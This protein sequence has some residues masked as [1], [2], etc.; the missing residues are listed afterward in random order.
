VTLKH[1]SF[2]EGKTAKNRVH[3]DIRCSAGPDDPEAEQKIEAHANKLAEA[4]GSVIGRHR[5]PSLT[6]VMLDPEGNEF[7]V[8]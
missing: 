6:V 1:E 8:T 2:P 3:L 4:G 7:C 5:D